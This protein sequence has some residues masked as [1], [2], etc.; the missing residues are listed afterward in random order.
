MKIRVYATATLML[1]FSLPAH[2]SGWAAALQA[3]GQMEQ[4]RQEH[5]LRQRAIEDPRYR[6]PAAY[7]APAVPQVPSCTMHQ[8]TVGDRI[9]NC[10]VC[11]GSTQCF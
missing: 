10:N 6:A 1:V 9:M 2:A 8:V 5:E 11:P 4:G 7:S 3:L